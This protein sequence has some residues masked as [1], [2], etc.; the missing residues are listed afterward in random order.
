MVNE[1]GGVTEARVVKTRLTLTLYHDARPLKSY[2]IA[3]GRGG[4]G[5]KERQGDKKT[6]EGEFYITEKLVL[7]NNHYLGSRWM[8][9]SYP[10]IEDAERGYKEGLISLSERDLIIHAINHRLPPPQ[11][12]ALGGGIGIHG[13][14]GNYADTHGDFWTDGC[15][16]LTDPD[17]GEIYDFIY[18]GRTR[19]VIEH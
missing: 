8:R 3:I 14:T 16:G 15:I 7:H 6:P 11:H 12:T 13:G 4:L 10:N 9:I 2:H 5:D 1:F 19:I 17:V 18:L